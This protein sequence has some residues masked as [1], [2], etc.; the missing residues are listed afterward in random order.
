MQVLDQR[1]L[2]VPF[3]SFLYRAVFLNAFLAIS[4]KRN[5]NFAMMRK[6]LEALSRIDEGESL[7][8]IAYEFGVGT[9]TL[10]GWKK[11][12]EKQSRIFA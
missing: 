1:P 2:R 7:K 5:H 10:S 12:I 9:S 6:K 11:K 3:V 4:T 8:K